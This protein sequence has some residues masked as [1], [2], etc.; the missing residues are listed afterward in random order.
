MEASLPVFTREKVT[1]DADRT[2]RYLAGEFIDPCTIELDLTDTC[3]RSCPSCPF[4]A[5]PA[6][7]RAL[8]LRFLDRL[9]GVLGGRTPGLILSGGEP[10]VAPEF[11]RVLALAR[12]RGFRQVATITNGTRLHLRP[13]QDALLEHGTAVRVSL[14]DWQNGGLNTVQETLARLVDLRERRDREGSGLEIGVSLLT[15]RARAPFFAAVAEAVVAS[16]A[17]DWLYFHPFCR[18]WSERPVQE[19]QETV[20]ESIDALLPG[21][22]GRIEVQVA[23]DRYGDRPLHFSS[24]HAA[25]FLLQ[26]GADGMNYLA[27]EAKYRPDSALLPLDERID[28]D[29]LRN[30][31]RLE[32]IRSIHSGNYAVIGTRH[33]GSVFSDTLENLLQGGNTREFSAGGSRFRYPDII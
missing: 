5:N 26:V 6:N 7:T 9:F 13:V 18:D 25:H 22:D 12:Q 27:P 30:P 11:P 16:G 29:F 2:S 21:L 17:A 32:R 14:Y 20:L 8:S 31:A 24:F 33:R 19:D 4:G 28:D 10:T 3:T 23:R 15:S 1:S